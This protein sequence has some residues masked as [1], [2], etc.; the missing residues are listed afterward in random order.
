MYAPGPSRGKGMLMYASPKF[1]LQFKFLVQHSAAD[2]LWTIGN[3]HAA[4]LAMRGHGFV[5]MKL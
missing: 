1:A 2:A 5:F 3:P 4:Y